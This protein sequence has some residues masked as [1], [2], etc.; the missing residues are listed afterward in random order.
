[1][2]TQKKV[3]VGFAVLLGVAL[4]AQPLTAYANRQREA[5]KAEAQSASAREGE[6]VLSEPMGRYYQRNAKRAPALPVPV[7]DATGAM[8][9]TLAS[10]QPAAAIVPVYDATGTMLKALESGKVPVPAA[11]M[12]A[13]DWDAER[14]RMTAMPGY[15]P[16]N[17]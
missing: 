11:P 1:M 9:D 7:Y 6:A 17:P 13:V 4:V 5:A 3:A 14:A 10:A 2:S 15:T 12:P 8:L 16:A